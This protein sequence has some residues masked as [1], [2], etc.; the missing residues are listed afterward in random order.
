M[1]KEDILL[2]KSNDGLSDEK[3]TPI[4]IFFFQATN[5]KDTLWKSIEK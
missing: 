3:T 4:Y 5:G 1:D 2:L